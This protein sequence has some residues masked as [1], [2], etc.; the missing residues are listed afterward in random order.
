MGS[1]EYMSPEQFSAPKTVDW[2][3][4]IWSIGVTLF[5]LL[6]GRGPFTGHELVEVAIK[7]AQEP[8]PPVTM[9]RGDVPMGLS[10][11]ILRCLEKDRTARYQDM[12]ELVAALAPFAPSRT[13]PLVERIARIVQ[14]GRTSR[15]PATVFAQP[16]PVP[17]QA[18]THRTQNATSWPPQHPVSREAATTAG[19]VTPMVPSIPLPTPNAR[20]GLLV[21]LG[22]TAGVLMMLIVGASLLR[23]PSGALAARNEPAQQ[24]SAAESSTSSLSPPTVLSSPVVVEGPAP[25]LSSESPSKPAPSNTTFRGTHSVTRATWRFGAGVYHGI[26]HTNGTTGYADVQFVHPAEGPVVVREDLRLQQSQ[27]GWAYVGSNPRYVDDGVPA[28]GFIPN[29]FYMEHGTGGAWNFV[30]TC[31][32]GTTICTRMENGR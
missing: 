4:D 22:V 30:E 32:V 6:A 29:V 17:G 31:A 5:E 24:P 16:L 20:N 21:A 28:S 14:E 19:V 2:R 18:P 27:R 25:E 8:A 3:T 9:L 12:A 15:L 23:K 13:H 10:S 1:P 7:I 26:I 11:V